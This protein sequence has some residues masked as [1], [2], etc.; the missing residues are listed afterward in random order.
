ML[1]MAG[2]IIR[3]PIVDMMVILP[4]L[5]KLFHLRPLTVQQQ[6]HTVYLDGTDLFQLVI[7]VKNIENVIRVV[8]HLSNCVTG[9]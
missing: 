3:L 4:K 7:N 1:S 8:H 2:S 5:N 9:S 6:E